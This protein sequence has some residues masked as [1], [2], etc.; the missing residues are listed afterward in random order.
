MGETLVTREQIVADLRKLGLAAGDLVIVHSSLSSIGHVEGGAET[1]IAALLEVLGEQGTLMMPT[2]AGPPPFDVRHTPSRLGEITEVFRKYP[3]VVRSFHPSHSV[4]VLGPKAAELIKGHLDSPTACGRETPFGRLIAMDG[5]ILLLGVDNDRNTT[6]HTLEEYV[7][8]PYLSDHEAAYL[9]DLGR[10]HVKV[11]KHYPGPHR[12]FIGVSP[13]LRR[14]G[15]VHVGKVGQ[16]LSQLIDA[17]RM[18]DVVLE[19]FARDPNLVLCDNPSCADCVMQRAKVRRHRLSREDFVLSAL[20][21]SVSAYPDEI[22]AEL[23]RAG[24]SDLVI[25][26]L[27]GRPVWLVPEKQLRRAAQT[28]SQE[29]I[30]VHAVYGPPDMGRLDREGDAAGLFGAAGLILPL[31]GE[32]VKFVD[33]L[34]R[35]RVRVFFENGPLPPRTCLELLTKAGAAQSFAFNPAAF[36]LLG[37]KPFLGA[38]NKTGLR[39]HIGLLFLTDATFGGQ[40]TLPG[41]GNAEVKELLSILRCR[42]FR[43]RVVLATGPSGPPF[44]ELVEAFWTLLESM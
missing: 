39:K 7:L 26:R 14:G 10:Q 12:N 33:H 29:H 16:A 28:F 8:A 21:S 18:H 35:D 43:G 32:T 15:A 11:L 4:A 20:A 44:R 31:V 2:F 37:E 23:N 25:D 27:H 9:D 3:D 19:A 38:F 41:R 5:K 24:I 22:V 13:L 6:M 34:R 40:F 30:T 36:A 1:V 42:S 17:K